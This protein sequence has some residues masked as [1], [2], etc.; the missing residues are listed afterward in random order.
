M[1]WT[2]VSHNLGIPAP[3][4]ISL[5]VSRLSVEITHHLPCL[6]KCPILALVLITLALSWISLRNRSLLL[7]SLVG[8]R[9]IF[10]PLST[11]T[12][13]LD[14]SYVFYFSLAACCTS[15]CNSSSRTPY[16]LNKGLLVKHWWCLASTSWTTSTSSPS[17]SHLHMSNGK[18]NYNAVSLRRKHSLEALFTH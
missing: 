11:S 5:K 15:L 12:H 13:I 9:R 16:S 2:K 6:T 1:I 7:L 8:R 4:T 18:L 3:W 17:T 14:A 10:L